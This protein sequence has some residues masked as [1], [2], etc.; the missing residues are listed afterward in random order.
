MDQVEIF[1]ALS[2]KTRLQILNWLKE[3]AIHFNEQPNADFENIGVCVGQIQNKAGLSQSTI[4]EYL[5]ILQRADLVCA[6]RIGQWTYY[7]RN[8]VGIEE[9][10]KIFNS[11]L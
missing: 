11:E 4:S 9:L 7:K 10:A 3:P 6:T 1:K 2:N 8:Q 5:S